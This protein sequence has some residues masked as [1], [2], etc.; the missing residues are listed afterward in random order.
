MTAVPI[1]VPWLETA[2][3]NLPFAFLSMRWSSP[4]EN[5]V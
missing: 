4:A 5:C 1:M 2:S 3:V